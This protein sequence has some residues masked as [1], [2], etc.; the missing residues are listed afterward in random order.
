MEF[1]FDVIVIGSGFG[2]SVSALRA[3]EKGYKVAVLESGKHY[4]AEDFAKN[5]WD[6]KKYLF[7]PGIGCR[8]I[9]R[10]TM[11][12]DIFILSGAGVGGGSLVYANTLYEPLE[13]F[14]KDK[15]WVNITDWK[16]ELS[17]FYRKAKAMLGVNKVPKIT[18]ADEVMIELAKKLNVEDSF[19][20]TDVGVFFGEPGKSVPDPF[21][22]GAGPARSGCVGCGG[23]MVGCRHNAKNSLDKNYLYFAQKLGAKI[24]A[25][26][27]A[28]D[29]IP[30]N[31]GGY[32]VITEKPGAWI[33]KNK[34]VIT[35]EKVVFSAGVL[36]TL[37]LLFKLKEKGR[38]PNLSNRL[39]HVVRTNSEAIVGA[40]AEEIP[41][42]DLTNGVAITSS[43]Y[44]DSQTHI[45]PCRYSKGSNSIS[46]LTTMM[47]DGGA[48]IS[49]RKKF[50]SQIV[51]KPK[52]FLKSLSKKNWSERSV[53]LLVMQTKD[54]SL[55]I[56]K[57]RKRLTTVAGHGEANPTYLPIANDSA[58]IVADI[59]GGEPWGSWGEALFN[60]PT[61]AHIIGG[62]CIGNS[63]DQ[64]VVDPYQRVFNYEGLYI[65]DGSVIGAN[66]GVNPSLTIT[67]MSERAMSFW[68]NKGMK[69]LRSM[70][71]KTYKPIAEIKPISPAVSDST[72]DTIPLK[73]SRKA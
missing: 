47:V 40:T 44:P 61:T 38:L 55:N 23:C 31:N 67:A 49:R 42:Q 46:V 56:L 14:Y 70:L 27:K 59:I 18:P 20:P 16:S 45:E 51:Q 60:A 68:P 65:A 53:I 57:K 28:V 10:I 54:N 36:G 30:L 41:A 1:D 73:L 52:V 24:F 26:T 4:R 22:D 63:P 66:L 6:I 11:L 29:L 37:N 39:G 5:S 50:I 48:G 71:G 9:Q 13:A 15:Q 64:G 17:P 58:R 62:A 35:A 34:R 33:N 32:A 12:K 8:G 19:K 43:I 72:L 7:A 25:E 21:F 69:D 2:G 3:S